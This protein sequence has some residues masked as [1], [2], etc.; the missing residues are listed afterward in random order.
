MHSVK[1]AEDNMVWQPR[2]TRDIS[3]AWQRQQTQQLQDDDWVTVSRTQAVCNAVNMMTQYFCYGTSVKQQHGATTTPSKLAKEYRNDRY[4]QCHGSQ[5]VNDDSQPAVNHDWTIFGTG[6]GHIE[7][8]FDWLGWCMRVGRVYSSS[9][10]DWT[11]CVVKL[12]VFFVNI[13]L[14]LFS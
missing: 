6:H 3:V 7:T 5:T 13:F 9:A 14:R 11:M 12:S 4:C 1:E 8:G 10:V 2:Q